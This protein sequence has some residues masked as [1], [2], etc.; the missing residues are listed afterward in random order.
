MKLSNAL[1]LGTVAGSLAIALPAQASHRHDADAT[2]VAK[3]DYG[4]YRRDGQE[5]RADERRRSDD[6]Q[7]LRRGDSKSYGYGYERRQRN[8]ESGESADDERRPNRRDERRG[9]RRDERRN[10]GAWR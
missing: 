2:V 5:G 3:R 4:D 10:N 8:T 6:R 1:M 7:S 9:E